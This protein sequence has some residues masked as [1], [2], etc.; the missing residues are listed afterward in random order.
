MEHFL[1]RF[2]LASLKCLLLLLGKA[3]MAVVTQVVGAAIILIMAE[4]VVVGPWLIKI[5]LR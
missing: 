1:L 3:E 5:V 2:L 4:L